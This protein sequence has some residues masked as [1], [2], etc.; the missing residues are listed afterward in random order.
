MVSEEAYL[1]RKQFFNKEK[2]DTGKAD[3]RTFKF[4]CSIL[5]SEGFSLLTEEGERLKQQQQ[6][7]VKNPLLVSCSVELTAKSG[8]KRTL[9]L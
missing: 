4:C 1:T 2:N 5:L 9:Q 3:Q 8:Q 7:E 6:Q